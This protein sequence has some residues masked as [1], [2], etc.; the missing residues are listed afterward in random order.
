[1][2]RLYSLA[3]L[4][5]LVILTASMSLATTADSHGT[6][7]DRCDNVTWKLPD[8]PV[9]DE[10]GTLEGDGRVFNDFS[11]RDFIALNW[12]A[13]EGKY[14]EADTSKTLGDKADIV[15][16]GSW[17]PLSDLFPANPDDTPPSWGSTTRAR[18]QKRSLSKIQLL[19]IKQGGFG[20]K[21]PTG[22]LIAQNCTYVRYET[23]M[24]KV[25]YDFIKDK[26]YYNSNKLPNGP[27]NDPSPLFGPSRLV[28]FPC[29]S[30][31]VK[32]AWM[33]LTDRDIV[34]R[35]YHIDV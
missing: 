27:K 28:A 6:P 29:G 10:I 1:M 17:R 32:A 21:N 22:P 15:V 19:T 9:F 7:S 18:G 23:L 26:Q 24:N 3:L 11:W 33:E 34:D 20:P 8:D 12:P 14:G 13:Q 25:A 30:I 2:Y 4:T 5:I 35:F 16:W 31:V